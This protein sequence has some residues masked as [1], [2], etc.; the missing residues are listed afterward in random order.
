MSGKIVEW[1]EYYELRPE[2]V[3]SIVYQESKGD[4]W[5][6]RYE[7]GFFDMYLSN[8]TA[9]NL[10]GYVPPGNLCSFE[11]EVRLRSFS[12]GIMQ[13]MG[14]TARWLGFRGTCLLQLCRIDIGLKFGCLYLKH[15]IDLKK[16]NEREG[17]AAYNGARIST[18]T[19]YDDKIYSHIESKNYL[20]VIDI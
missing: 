20:E 7:P 16:G 11:T 13:C 17:V 8:K 10:S 6:A 4:P 18:D 3:A 12:I 1:A 5:A 19:L 2:L 14:E 15:L 9:A